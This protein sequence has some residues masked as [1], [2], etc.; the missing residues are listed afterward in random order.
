MILVM[1]SDCDDEDEEEYSEKDAEFQ[2]FQQINNSISH[3]VL[4]IYF[5]TQLLAEATKSKR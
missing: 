4:N 3:N 2:Y 5:M 1:R